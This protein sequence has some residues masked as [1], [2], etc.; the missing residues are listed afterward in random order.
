MKY[1]KPIEFESGIITSFAKTRLKTT[2]NC[3]IPRIRL[4]THYL[5]KDLAIIDLHRSQ[6]QGWSGKL[7]CLAQTDMIGTVVSVGKARIIGI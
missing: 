2:L 6:V 3:F 4:I 5:R 7:S 1:W